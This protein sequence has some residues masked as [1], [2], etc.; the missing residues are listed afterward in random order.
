MPIR[1]KR[2]HEAKILPA[3]QVDVPEYLTDR[4]REVFL[5]LLGELA[6]D[7][8]VMKSR[9]AV[10]ASVAAAISQYE[11]AASALAVTDDLSSPEA[12]RL[13]AQLKAF[14]TQ[15]LASM[16]AVGLTPY[17]DDMRSRAVRGEIEREAGAQRPVAVSTAPHPDWAEIARQERKNAK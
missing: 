6:H 2:I 16:R 14:S 9:Q 17:R 4:G 7:Q 12:G 11:A 8:Q 1:A 3:V 15:A 13:V 5:E 10:V